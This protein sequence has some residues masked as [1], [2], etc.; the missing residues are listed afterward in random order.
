MI[1]HPKKAN[2]WPLRLEAPKNSAPMA[3]KKSSK[4]T[5]RPESWDDAAKPSAII[6][7]LKGAKVEDKL[8]SSNMTMPE[9]RFKYPLIFILI[10]SVVPGL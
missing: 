7:T 4:E 2:F 9:N 5:T 8:P 3:A 10:F 1:K 6:P